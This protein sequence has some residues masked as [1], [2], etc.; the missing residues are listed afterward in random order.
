MSKAIY[1]LNSQVV[2]QS[3]IQTSAIC[4]R[5]AKGAQDQRAQYHSGQSPLSGAVSRAGL[6]HHPHPFVI[7]WECQHPIDQHHLRSYPWPLC[8]ERASRE[9]T[10]WV[11]FEACPGT[12]RAHHYTRKACGPLCSGCLLSPTQHR[13]AREFMPLRAAMK[14]R[15]VES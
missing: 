5:Y 2:T 7:E 13:S 9:A 4:R 15:W 11:L 3:P 8:E 6:Q 14:Q 10:S 12:L 1:P